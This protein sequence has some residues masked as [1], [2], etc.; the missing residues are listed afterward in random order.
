M[1]LNEIT[2]GRYHL[3]IDDLG[4]LWITDNSTGGGGTF[5]EDAL[6]EIIDVFYKDNF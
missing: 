3:L 2:I 4:K 5:E 1:E 6:E